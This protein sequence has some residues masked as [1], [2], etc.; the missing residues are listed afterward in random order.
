[1]YAAYTKICLVGLESAKKLSYWP[2]FDPFLG[3]ISAA[4]YARCSCV[5]AAYTEFISDINRIV[6]CVYAAYTSRIHGKMP[7]WARK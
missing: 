5:Y 1:V 4:V 3:S 2:Y 7:F 6:A